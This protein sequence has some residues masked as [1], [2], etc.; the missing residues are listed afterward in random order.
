M[1]R[2]TGSAS[3]S[4]DPVDS[5]RQPRTHIFVAAALCS[6]AGSSPVHIRNMSASGALIES[7]LLPQPGARV[8]LRRGSLEA[9]G[10]IAWQVDRRAG[11]AFDATVQVSAWL[12][13]KRA[14]HQDRVDQM[15]ADIR[16]GPLAGQGGTLRPI[17]RSVDHSL[18]SELLLLRMD[19]DNLGSALITDPNLIAAHPEVQLLDISM[20][21]I[22]RLLGSLKRAA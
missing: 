14:G 10:T 12:S 15:I 6:N 4:A 9:A 17:A 19:L 1:W 2:V 11:I 3:L 8:V 5:R 16:G 13:G 7:P 21:R 18:E 22:D 20:Q